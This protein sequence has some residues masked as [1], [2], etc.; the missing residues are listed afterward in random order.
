MSTEDFS[1]YVI[2]V[3]AGIGFATVVLAMGYY[4]LSTV[5]RYHTD[6]QFENPH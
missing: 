4:A 6:R 5:A 2:E 3:F 1:Q